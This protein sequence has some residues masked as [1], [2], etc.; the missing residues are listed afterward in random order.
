MKFQKRVGCEI[1]TNWAIHARYIC[2]TLRR[3]AR[4]RRPTTARVGEDVGRGGRKVVG[5]KSFSACIPPHF[6]LS[7]KKIGFGSEVVFERKFP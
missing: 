4:P 6:C 5:P 3:G 2:V 7:P 1:V